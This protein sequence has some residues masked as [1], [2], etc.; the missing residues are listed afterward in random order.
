MMSFVFCD[1]AD[2]D[3]EAT[4][5]A[6]TFARGSVEISSSFPSNSSK[7]SS[8]TTLLFFCTVL[9]VLVR[10]SVKNKDKLRFTSGRSIECSFCRAKACSIWCSKISNDAPREKT[11]HDHSDENR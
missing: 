3:F 4:V 1:D 7:I 6:G 5:D 11:R 9:R 10:W 8:T 2:I